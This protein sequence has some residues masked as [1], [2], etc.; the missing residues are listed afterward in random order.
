MKP[1]DKLI[2]IDT[3]NSITKDKV[4]DAIVEAIGRRY[5]HLTIGHSKVQISKFDVLPA[6][7]CYPH[8]YKIFGTKESYMEYE[9]YQ[10]N[11][12]KFQKYIRHGS[13]IDRITPAQIKKI[14]KILNI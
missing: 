13:R 5:I 3:S 9:V 7:T 1:G 11:M 4:F 2:A 6:D 10:K 14:N 12:K 8:S